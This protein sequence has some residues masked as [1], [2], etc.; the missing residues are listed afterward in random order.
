MSQEIETLADA[1]S[2]EQTRVR[3]CLEIYQSIKGGNTSFA[4]AALTD[5]LWRA[6]QAVAEYDTVAMI[7][8][9]KE[10]RECE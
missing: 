1:Y 10:M 8:M 6:E 3:E 9:L 2:K 5:V 4:I 7:G